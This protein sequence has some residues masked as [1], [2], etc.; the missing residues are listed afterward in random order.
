MGDLQSWAFPLLM[1]ALGALFAFAPDE[2]LIAVRGYTGGSWRRTIGQLALI[3][4]GLV[5]AFKIWLWIS[6]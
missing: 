2:F 1:I 4:G 5:T 3:I 6:N